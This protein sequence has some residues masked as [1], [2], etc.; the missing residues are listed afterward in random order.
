MKHIICIACL[1]LTFTERGDNTRAGTRFAEELIADGYGYAF[2]VAAADLDA[3]GDLDL[4]SGDTDKGDFYW[5]ENN[6]KGKFQKHVVRQG[7]PGWFER[8]VIGDIN[9]DKRPDIAIVKNLDGHLVWFEHGGQPKE[10]GNW[11]RHV[12]TTDLRRAYDVVLVDLN[13]DGRLD[14]VAS[15]WVG[16]HFAWFENPGPNGF[17]QEW[18]KRLIDENVN[19]TRNVRLGDFN[20]DGKLDLLG[21]AHNAPLTAWY[22]QPTDPNA[23]LWIRHVVDEKSPGPT[24]GHAV[25]MDGDKDADI[26]MALGFNVAKD[27]AETHQI[28]WYENVGSPGSGTGW[29]K[30]VVGPLDDAFEAIVG[31]VDGDGDLDIAATG[32]GD[33][34]RVAWFENAGD[35]KGA[36]KKHVLKDAWR[37]A[38]QIILFDADGDKR[39]DLAATAERG[40]NELRLWRNVGK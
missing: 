22:E 26:L 28:V 10:S 12:I 32:W 21:T 29:K 25:D 18:K 20:G 23:K 1:C 14:A 13:G 3:D 30:H 4:T 35:P 33:P 6:G 34:G 24:H 2:A 39:L 31:D 37:R 36:W 17:D 27:A 7:E 40:T 19:E 38:N 15:A 9:G 16:N 5:F 8:H 11:K